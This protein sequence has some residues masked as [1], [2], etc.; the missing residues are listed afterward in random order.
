VIFSTAWN[1]RPVRRSGR[2]ENVTRRSVSQ[3]AAAIAA[4]ITEWPDAEDA[5]LGYP[6]AHL[7][8]ACAPARWLRRLVLAR[9]RPH[10]C[11]IEPAH[12]VT[13]RSP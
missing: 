4:V 9:R 6:N 7:S 12:T 3:P 8:L 5:E 1:R 10:R 13:G 2:T 11:T